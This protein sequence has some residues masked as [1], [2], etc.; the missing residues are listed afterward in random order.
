M[1]S[2]T[3]DSLSL[4]TLEK[5]V[6]LTWRKPWRRAA[7]KQIICHGR[8][9][10]REVT[11]ILL[12]GYLQVKVDVLHIYSILF[13]FRENLTCNCN[14]TV[15]LPQFHLAF[16]TLAHL[17]GAA[18]DSVQ[19]LPTAFEILLSYESQCSFFKVHLVTRNRKKP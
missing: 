15:K 6:L 3:L 9:V 10:F 5:D 4:T 8:T 7:Q 19:F 16:W 2:D 18:Q 12:I 13:V 1:E 17:L 14:S 11:C